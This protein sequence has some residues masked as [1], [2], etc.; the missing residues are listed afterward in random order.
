MTKSRL[1][2]AFLLLAAIVA[3]ITIPT[4]FW[5]GIWFGRVLDNSTLEGYLNHKNPRLIQHAL[6]QIGERIEKKDPTVHSWY[7]AVAEFSKSP[8]FNLQITAAWVMGQDTDS[9]LFHSTLLQM[10]ADPK[11]LVRRNA[12]LALSRFGDDRALPELRNMLIPYPIR[13][14]K[15]GSVFYLVSEGDWVNKGGNIANLNSNNVKIPIQSDASGRLQTKL[16]PEGSLTTAGDTLMLL[17]PNPKHVWESLRA[18]YLLGGPEELE[19]VRSVLSES[20]FDQKIHQQAAST[21]KA[22]QK[23]VEQQ[24]V[25]P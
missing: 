21:A 11:P 19:I 16:L 5:H 4:L 8:L 14:P 13:S 22:I 10:L 9:D 20:S 1:R 25:I 12:A 24:E 18:L 15:S 2:F 6:T 7:S 17:K 3:T 23:R